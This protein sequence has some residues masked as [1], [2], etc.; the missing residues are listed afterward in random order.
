MISLFLTLPR[1]NS[2]L[3][4][5]DS[6]PKESLYDIDLGPVI[7]VRGQQ[8]RV[9]MFDAYISRS[10]IG[11]ITPP[12][13]SWQHKRLLILMTHLEYQSQITI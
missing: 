2:T 6:S 9:I 10:P 12:K 1:P 8:S 4:A 7:L 3:S 5:N 13:V 11:I